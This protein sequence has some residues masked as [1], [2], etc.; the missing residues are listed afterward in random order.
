MN[1]LSIGAGAIGI[2]V[3]GSLAHVGHQVL[4]VDKPEVVSVL[5]ER[6]I[7]LDLISDSYQLRNIFAEENIDSALTKMDFD[8]CF[9]AIKSYD[10]DQFIEQIK[11]FSER[12]PVI[13]CMQNGVENE[14]KLVNLLGSNK[15][16]PAS[17]TSAISKKDIGSV[18]VERNRGLGISANHPISSSLKNTFR[19]AGLN[20]RLYQKPNA[21]KWS[22]ML[23]NLLGNASSAILNLPPIKIFADPAFFRLE[24]Y[25]IREALKV[26]QALQ[27]KPV[28]LPGTPIRT[29]SF[30]SQSL[31]LW[32]A[33]TIMVQSVGKGRGAKMPSFYI[34]LYSGSNQSEV[35]FLNGA[36]VRFGNRLGIK[37]PVN[38]YLNEVL[39]KLIRGEIPKDT[40]ASNPLKLINELEL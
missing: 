21:M 12:M 24:I 17:I 31:P 37:V 30:V 3:G 14:D 10:T 9:L 22:K 13:I 11:P 35:D 28:D 5:H 33:R 29:L 26:M 32:L 36:V 19:Y 23:S 40:Y 1:I 38:Q 8:F 4:F 34:D 25:Q 16:I 15:V 2:Y 27:L 39:N 7:F 18:V 6:G 20:T